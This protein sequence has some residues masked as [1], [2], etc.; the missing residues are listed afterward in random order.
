MENFKNMDF[1]RNVA[2]NEF[3]TDGLPPDYEKLVGQEYKDRMRQLENDFQS[4]KWLPLDIPRIDIDDHEEFFH[5][6]N[7]Q[8]IDILRHRVCVA[9]PWSKEEH[10]L[11]Q[12]SSWYV[13][14]FRGL[15][16][17][18]HPMNNL[19]MNPFLAKKYKGDSKQLERIVDQ[20]FEYFPM[21]TFWE[22]FLWESLIPIGPHRDKSAYWK[23]PTEFR[24][25]LYDE[26]T[27]PTLYVVDVEHGDKNYIDCPE[28]TNSFCWSNGSQ[29]HG[30]DYF[31]KRKVILCMNGI[32]HS[33]KCRD[34]FTRSVN[35]YKSK[36]NYNLEI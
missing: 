14:Q 13:P 19:E 18:S 33:T 8:S 2:K 4:I 21:H 1:F 12:K 10:P 23:C 7:D 26:N 29:I 6:W 35:K 30:S 16:L 27:D 24:A 31:G 17:W 20:V 9:E 36:L 3:V 11:G 22:I 15:T 28:D 25:M 32:Q 34:L 5:I